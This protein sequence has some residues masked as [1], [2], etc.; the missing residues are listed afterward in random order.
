M[1]AAIVSGFSLLVVA[2]LLFVTMALIYK[3][4][5]K[6][7]PMMTPLKKPK[8]GGDGTL[9]A[10]NEPQSAQYLV[11]S[12]SITS[13]GSSPS[14][15]HLESHLASR[16]SPL[17]YY[18]PGLEADERNNGSRNAGPHAVSY[19]HEE[20]YRPIQIMAADATGRPKSYSKV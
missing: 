3:H 6:K 10:S 9:Y 17:V 13:F 7:D 12:M 19:E 11:S 8:K 4:L 5:G 20:G 14:D 15:A 16:P 2:F 18:N 1:V